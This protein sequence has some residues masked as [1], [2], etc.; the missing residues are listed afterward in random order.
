MHNVGI[1]LFVF[2]VVFLAFFIP[3]IIICM[4]VRKP[5]KPRKQ[6]K[7]NVITIGAPRA[8]PVQ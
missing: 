3:Y 2:T 7:Y 6:K 5:R 4:K 8:A 1:A